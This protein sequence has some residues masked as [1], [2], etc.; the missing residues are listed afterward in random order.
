MLPVSNT[1]QA[2]S[3]NRFAFKTEPLS[4][5]KRAFERFKDATNAALFWEMG[6][7]KTKTAIDLMAYKFIDG[8]IDTAVIVCPVL[9][10]TQWAHQIK[11]HCNIDTHIVIYRNVSKTRREAVLYP[12][13]KNRNSPKLLVI[14]V[15]Y[16]T[17]IGT[18]CRHV[19]LDFFEARRVLMI[20]DEATYIKNPKSV[21][22]KQFLRLRKYIKQTLLLTGTALAKRPSDVW[23]LFQF[24]DP[25]I[26]RQPYTAFLHQYTIIVPRSIKTETGYRVV[27]TTLSEKTYEFLRSKINAKPNTSGMDRSAYIDWLADKYGIPREILHEIAN[28]QQFAPYRD[29]FSL[30]ERIQPYTDFITEEDKLH[31]EKN[32]KPIILHTPPSIIKMINK[33]R[34]AAYALYKDGVMSVEN[35]MALRHKVFQILGGHFIDDDNTA[36]PISPNDKEDFIADF[37][38][39]VDDQVLIFAVYT[40]EIDSLQALM[41]QLEVSAGA[42]TGSMPHHARDTVIKLF[43]EKHIQVLICNPAVASF[44]LNF[45]DVHYQIWYSRNFNTETR[46]QAEARTLRYGSTH[47]TTYIDLLYDIGIEQRVYKTNRLAAQT[48]VAFNTESTERL[49][50]NELFDTARDN[51]AT[52][53]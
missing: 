52:Y 30:K 6:H 50:I 33:L 40:E 39:T 13:G 51:D 10:I 53:I 16:D 29:I 37:V 19:F 43:Q 25:N 24:M 26:L 11:A 32:Y 34:A 1:T 3:D 12:D 14:L 9:L 2:G 8:Q 41:H 44:G 15:A 35:E 49:T 31:L 17:V 20:L 38:K 42:L 28:L 22:T 48:N 18:A 23:S 45:P 4:H 47:P 21:R 46:I 36:I 27:N 7:G 5:Q